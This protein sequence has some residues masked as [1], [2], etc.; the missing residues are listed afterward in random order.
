MTGASL[1][2]ASVLPALGSTAQTTSDLPSNQRPIGYTVTDQIDG[3]GIGFNQAGTYT[4]GAYMP[5]SML[6]DYKGCPIVGIRVAVARD[7]GRTN[8]Q[9]HLVNNGEI[10][11]AH[12][13]KQRLY[14]GWNNI[15]FNGYDYTITGTDDIFFGFDYTETEEMIA[16][17]KCG[18]D[19][20]Q[21]ERNNAFVI[22][23]N[24]EYGQVTGG[25]ALC[26]QLIVDVTNMAP[27]NMS[28]SF[29]DNGFK[30]KTPGE[31]L[32]VYAMVNSTGL[33]TVTSYKMACRIDNN[34]PVYIDVTPEKP[35]EYGGN[36]SFEHTFDLKG[37][38]NGG[39][40]MNIYIAAINGEEYASG[41]ERGRGARF[42]V[43]TNS[44]KRNAA[45]VEIYSDQYSSNSAK[46]D[47]VVELAKGSLGETM[48]TV[49]NFRPG[50]TLSV[51]DGS[52]LHDL[53]A[54]TWPCWTVN[55][56]HFPGEV[57]V[58][59]DMNDYLSVFPSEIGTAIFEEL[60]MQD[61]TTPSFADIAL[62]CEV[63]DKNE[64]TVKA[65]GKLLPEATS[66][67]GDIAL[68]LLI[69]EDKVSAMQTTDSGRK[70]KSINNVLRGY[71][72]TATGEIIE[73]DNG[74]YIKGF[75]TVIPDSWNKD[76]LCVVGLLSMAGIPSMTDLYD[77]DIINAAVSS[78]RNTSGVSTVVSEDNLSEE[79][80]FSLDGI[81][82]AAED[83]TSGIYIKVCAD[84]SRT[85]VIV[86]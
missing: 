86:K 73:A 43:Y 80:Y 48:I 27:R 40:D 82:C 71:V 15:Y 22:Y 29:F 1:T 35:L 5:A 3:E 12:Q 38:E 23:Q 16:E 69:T 62:D 64:L 17:K 36:D 11:I 66:I 81:R 54:Y 53:Y 55:R 37:I 42:A 21:G 85:K 49:R 39:H 70:Q 44:V 32:S 83:L 74:D 31:G 77:Y 18:L 65:S 41:E 57:H 63:N 9:I 76:N 50:N 56:S 78:V 52:Y 33:E 13:Q 72:T 26:I 34:E 25:G 24:G 51:D 67:F 45:Y 30:Y 4:V 84:G 47:D 2:L 68:T 20:V 61:A 7:L 6:E 28:I 46:L 59:Y 14:T 10:N 19:C 75:K 60:V 8:S 79:I 58:A